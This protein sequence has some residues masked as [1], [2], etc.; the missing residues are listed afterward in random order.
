MTSSYFVFDFRYS[1]L[2]PASV[3][4]ERPE[5]VLEVRKTR[6][7]ALLDVDD[8]IKSVL[9]DDDFVS[10]GESDVPSLRLDKNQSRSLSWI[11]T[12]LQSDASNPVLGDVEV[13]YVPEQ[14][15]PVFEN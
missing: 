4:V 5:Q 14:V 11:L 7:G 10:V 1:K 3:H 13:P 12:V 15:Y 9:D 6:G 2:K 8:I